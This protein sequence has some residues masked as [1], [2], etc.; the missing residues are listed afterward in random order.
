LGYI[1]PFTAHLNRKMNHEENNANMPVGRHLDPDCPD[2][3][4]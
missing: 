1:R 2:L 4:R 3:R